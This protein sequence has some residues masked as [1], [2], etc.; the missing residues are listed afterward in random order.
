[1]AGRRV[2]ASAGE[3]QVKEDARRRNQGAQENLHE[4]LINA[5]HSVARAAPYAELAGLIGGR[6]SFVT[7][8]V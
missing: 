7:E 5:T 6:G 4:R 1:M 8:A 2:E 3:E